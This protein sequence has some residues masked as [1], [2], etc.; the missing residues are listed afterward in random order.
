MGKLYRSS[1]RVIAGVCA[2]LAE[3]F[4]LDAKIVRIVTVV[5]ALLLCGAVAIAYLILALILPV[6]N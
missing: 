5:A 1:D 4:N 6:K 2:G 3:E